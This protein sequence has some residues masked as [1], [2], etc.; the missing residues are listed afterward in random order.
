MQ[1]A[2]G[3][4]PSGVATL[5]IAGGEDRI[6]PVD[7]CQMIADGISGAEFRVLDGIGHYLSLEDPALFRRTVGRHLDKHGGAAAF[8]TY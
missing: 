8:A 7:S 2:H 6:A 4:G 3:M 1:C 5:V